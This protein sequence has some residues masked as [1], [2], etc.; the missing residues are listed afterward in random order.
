MIHP[1]QYEL[2]RARHARCERDAERRRRVHELQQAAAAA[3]LLHRVGGIGVRLW[4][5]LLI[6][7][8][9]TAAR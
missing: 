9:V 2:E 1:M 8:R 4:L 7:R 3:P 6:T 5:Q